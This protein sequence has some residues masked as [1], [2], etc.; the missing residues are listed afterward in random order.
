MALKAEMERN[1]GFGRVFETIQCVI[2]GDV[3]F[4][5][6]TGRLISYFIHSNLESYSSTFLEQARN[7][8]PLLQKLIC[9]YLS[10]ASTSLKQ[11]VTSNAALPDHN[12]YYIYHVRGHTNTSRWLWHLLCLIMSWKAG[13]ICDLNGWG[14]ILCS[15]DWILLYLN[16]FRFLIVILSF[17]TEGEAHNEMCCYIFWWLEWVC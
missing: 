15:N 16:N 10:T 11:S 6:S 5:L 12:I 14:S 17:D 7:G 2:G 13:L 9:N 3:L 1:K 4:R 8:D